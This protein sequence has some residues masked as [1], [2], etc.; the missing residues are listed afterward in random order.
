MRVNQTI[1]AGSA[2]M[3]LRE[4]SGNAQSPPLFSSP[5]ARPLKGR[6]KGRLDLR[7]TSFEA[8]KYIE[9]LE[10]QL[11]VTQESMFSPNTGKSL[12]EKVK[13]LEG[14]VQELNAQVEEWEER[15][16][17]RVKEAVEHKTAH[18]LDLRRRIKALEDE[19]VSKSVIIQELEQRDAQRMHH[20]Q[21]SVDNLRFAQEKLEHEKKGLE[22]TNRSLERR[23]DVLTELLAQSP[24]RPQH[25]L[26]LSSPTRDMFRR[27][28]RPTS[29]MAKVPSSADA[30]R[31]SGSLSV[32]PSPNLSPG[33]GLFSPRRSPTRYDS[34]VAMGAQKQAIDAQ[35]FDSGIGES[36]SIR[37]FGGTS[38]RHSVASHESS[39]PSAWGLPLPPSPSESKSDKPSRNRKLRRFASGST[40]LKPLVLPSITGTSTQQVQSSTSSNNMPSPNHDF[41]SESLDPTMAFLTQDNFDTPTQPKR[42]SSARESTWAAE[43]ALRALE[44]NSQDHF[45]S[46]EDILAGQDHTPLSTMN[47]P[48]YDSGTLTT[49][50]QGYD[51]SGLP[52][53]PLHDMI[54]EEPLE[55]YPDQTLPIGPALSQPFFTLEN[56]LSIADDQVLPDLT[57]VDLDS[58]GVPPLP[59]LELSSLETFEPRFRVDP[60]NFGFNSNMP[61]D[62][63]VQVPPFAPT[64]PQQADTPYRI[65]QFNVRQ[66]KPIPLNLES[67]PLNNSQLRKRRRSARHSGSSLEHFKT[68]TTLTPTPKFKRAVQAWPNVVPKPKASVSPTIEATTSTYRATRGHR[69]PRS[70]N[71][72]SKPS[73][74]SI[75]R[76]AMLGSLVRYATHLARFRADPTAVARR[77]IANAWRSQWNRLGGFS[78]W[79]LG[80]FLGRIHDEAKADP[81]SHWSREDANKR[82]WELAYG[83]VEGLE[84]VTSDV[85]DTE[86]EAPQ[87]D[88]RRMSHGNRRKDARI[89]KRRSCR[90]D[91]KPNRTVTFDDRKNRRCSKCAVDPEPDEKDRSKGSWTRSIYLWGK[92]SV[93]LMLAIGGAV[94]EGPAAMLKDCESCSSD[95]AGCISPS[96]SCSATSGEGAR[97]SPESSTSDRYSSSDPGGSDTGQ[98]MGFT[99]QCPKP[100]SFTASAMTDRLPVSSGAPNRMTFGVSPVA[101]HFGNNAKT[102]TPCKTRKHGSTR[103]SSG[104]KQDRKGTA[105]PTRKL[106]SP[107]STEVTPPTKRSRRKLEVQRN[108]LAADKLVSFGTPSRDGYDTI[109]DYGDNKPSRARPPSNMAIQIYD[110]EQDDKENQPQDS[111]DYDDDGDNRPSDF[112]GGGGSEPDG[113][114]VTTL[115]PKKLP[116]RQSIQDV[117]WFQNLGVLDFDRG[118]I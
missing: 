44:G 98:R 94:V 72:K 114:E 32:Q 118:R 77:V 22:E 3:K 117:T 28:P 90:K 43:D 34:H 109:N 2:T 4:I 102:N 48:L 60:S 52:F 71:L 61:P 40:S 110:D 92:F 96:H 7:K 42:R 104:K 89:R 33:H 47:Y 23:N 105:D 46:F 27:T 21:S 29:M 12:E 74:S 75:S 79:V 107:K 67:S 16:D 9:H 64:P 81:Q 35:S 37:S 54:A 112:G 11:Q 65:F 1:D 26:D 5:L 83:G 78:W 84:T 56:E 101:S 63:P 58:L 113:D 116:A 38:Q 45:S 108:M 13:S 17:L 6:K 86:D 14:K 59:N 18:E 106:C 55:T 39:S 57:D 66:A 15:F 73:V 87:K 80:L 88:V 99:G 68:I 19:L 70:V 51:M 24:T 50:M 69:R 10:S 93:A 30:V 31:V 85:H 62:L 82:S 20:D 76:P 103:H 25:R 115:R 8:S 41:S 36:C 49:D 97:G 100:N 53:N 91:H 95:S 111:D